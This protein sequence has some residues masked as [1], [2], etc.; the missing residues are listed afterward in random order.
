ML[1]MLLD[2]P[3]IFFFSRRS[4]HTRLQG[5]WSSDVCSSDLVT[6]WS[7]GAMLTLRS[8]RSADSEDEGEEWSEA[9]VKAMERALLKA[10]PREFESLGAKSTTGTPKIGRASCR[11]RGW[12][13]GRGG[14]SHQK[15]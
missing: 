9:A 1:S 10:A 3:S 6:P 4:R 15:S 8:Y 13:S 5:D 14:L 11:E 7:D 12:R 2:A